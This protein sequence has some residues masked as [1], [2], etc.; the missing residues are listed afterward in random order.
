MH[1][2][3]LTIFVLIGRVSILWAKSEYI[4]VLDQ[5]TCWNCSDPSG[6]EE[7]VVG[8]NQAMEAVNWTLEKVVHLGLIANNSAS[9]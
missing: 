4:L 1:S 6:C 7:E 3:I 9:K 5:T 8:A 2:L